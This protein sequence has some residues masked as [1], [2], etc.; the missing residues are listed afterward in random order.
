MCLFTQCHG[1]CQVAT[2]GLAGS[3]RPLLDFTMLATLTCPLEGGEMV[4]TVSNSEVPERRAFW[5]PKHRQ[6]YVDDMDN[7]FFERKKKSHFYYAIR[8]LKMSI[9]R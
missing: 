5:N 2:V 8:K 6:L 1:V 9:S 3:R 7:A 4:E